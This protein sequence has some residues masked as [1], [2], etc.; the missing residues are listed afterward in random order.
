MQMRLLMSGA[1]ILAVAATIAVWPA[2]ADDAAGPA[3]PLFTRE[4]ALACPTPTMLQVAQASME[5]G[6]H[7]APAGMGTVLAVPVGSPVE[8]ADFGCSIHRDGQSVSV[9]TRA[10]SMVETD[11]GWFRQAALRDEKG[12]PSQPSLRPQ[13]CDKHGANCVYTDVKPY[14]KVPSRSR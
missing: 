7:Y 14:E 8:A 2:Q 10:A 1:G 5:K 3:R 9:R 11:Q 13:L 12:G 6:W 4:G